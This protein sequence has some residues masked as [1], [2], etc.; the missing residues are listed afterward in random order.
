MT[1]AE[2]GGPYAYSTDAS[3]RSST[4]S[5]QHDGRSATLGPSDPT[6]GGSIAYFVVLLVGFSLWVAYRVGGPANA[7]LVVP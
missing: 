7:A 5:M 6:D 4:I 1:G 3:R 2:P